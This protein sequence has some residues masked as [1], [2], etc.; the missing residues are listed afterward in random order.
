MSEV[1]DR[2]AMAAVVTGANGG[3]GLEVARGLAARHAH[4][5][6]AVRSR[7]RGQAAAIA[8]QAGNPDASLQV[9]ELDLADLA[10]VH[11]FAETVR[12][13][14][15]RLDLLINNAGIGSPSLQH[16]VDGF[17]LV[18]G[19]NHLGPFALTGLLLPAILATPKARVVTI[20]SMAHGV[21]KIDLDN[22]DGSKGY[23]DMQ[24][25]AQSKLAALLFAYELQRRLAVAGK[26]QISVACHPGWVAT[27]MTSKSKNPRPGAVERLVRALTRRLAPG[28]AQGARPAIYA[29]TSPDVRGGDFIGPGGLFGVW[30]APARVRSSALSYDEELAHR[31]WQ[32]SESMTGVHYAFAGA[33]Q[34]VVASTSSAGW[35]LDIKAGG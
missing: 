3:I 12:S 19:T 23:A 2:G 26:S 5:V 4:V 1:P 17:E 22:L 35:R 8:I 29:A 18:F 7:E 33:Q 16:T 15:D 13:R 25:Y 24:A 14:L 9:L 10:S 30:G 31:L 28:P 21:G 6:L 11:S 20:S 34:E 32:V 27:N